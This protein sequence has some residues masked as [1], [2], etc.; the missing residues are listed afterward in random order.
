MVPVY[1]C[2]SV[3]MLGNEETDAL[4]ED[5][6]MGNNKT[7][8]IKQWFH[9]QFKLDKDQQVSACLHDFDKV[10]CRVII[11]KPKSGQ[12]DNENKCGTIDSANLTISSQPEVSKINKRK[13]KQCLKESDKNLPTEDSSTTTT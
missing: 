9:R 1:K 3:F 5:R 7:E 13:M 4:L 2:K 10:V 6:Y 8:S 11:K 12:I